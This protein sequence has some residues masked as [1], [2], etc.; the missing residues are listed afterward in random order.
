[1]HLYNESPILDSNEMTVEY[2][3]ENLKEGKILEEA[4]NL[5][6]KKRYGYREVDIPASMAYTI[7][8]SELDDFQVSLIRP[9]FH[10][11]AYESATNLDF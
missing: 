2:I 4:Q 8:N 11:I 9:D 6:Y 10:R 1:M 7:A 3:Y 5:V